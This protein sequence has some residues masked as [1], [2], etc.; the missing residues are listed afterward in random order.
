VTSEL[1][2][3]ALA[4]LLAD[5]PRREA[6]EA[7]LVHVAFLL[8]QDDQ[9]ERVGRRLLA[10]ARAIRIGPPTSPGWSDTRSCGR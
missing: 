7:A 3:G 9:V 1:L 8:L 4:Q 10:A 6:L 5:D 2:R